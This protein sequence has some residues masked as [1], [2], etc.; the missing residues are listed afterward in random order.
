MDKLERYN[1]NNNRDKIFEYKNL[2]LTRFSI[3][4]VY[5]NDGSGKKS[6]KKI[7]NGGYKEEDSNSNTKFGSFILVRKII[8]HIEEK[9]D[10]N[11]IKKLTNH[12]KITV[13]VN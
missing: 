7:S 11:K 4:V 13:I 6:I 10:F 2:S 9:S 5:I 12:K 3:Y 1:S 8:I